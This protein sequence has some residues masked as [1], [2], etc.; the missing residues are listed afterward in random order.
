MT[1]A[2]PVGPPPIRLLDDG[3][4]VDHADAPRRDTLEPDAQTVV[5][6]G[7]ALSA[8]IRCVGP[9]D[10]DD[11]GQGVGVRRVG[12]RAESGRLTAVRPGGRPL[13]HDLRRVESHAGVLRAGPTLPSGY[14]ER[15]LDEPRLVRGGGRGPRRGFSRVGGR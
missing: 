12:R 11:R 3:V 2:G 8:R 5:D 4:L 6:V 14:P 1:R 7:Q 13:D 10:V 15:S 9:V